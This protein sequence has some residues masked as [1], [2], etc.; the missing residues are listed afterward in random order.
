[1]QRCPYCGQ[2]RYPDSSR[3]LFIGFGSGPFLWGFPGWGW[4]W[5]H[6]HGWGHGWGGHWRDEDY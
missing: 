2:T 4:G 5:G 6:H 3:Q 1:M